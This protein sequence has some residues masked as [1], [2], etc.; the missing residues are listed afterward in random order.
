MLNGMCEGHQLE[1]SRFGH[2]LKDAALSYSHL[3]VSEA[4]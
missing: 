1:G 4:C 2:C 3:E